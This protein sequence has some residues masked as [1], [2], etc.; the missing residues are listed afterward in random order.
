M[1]YEII[2]E[3]DLLKIEAGKG[4]FWTTLAG[5]AIGNWDQIK[6]GYKEGNKEDVLGGITP[7]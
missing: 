4:G 3:K 7:K 2:S 5:S 1:R 6:G